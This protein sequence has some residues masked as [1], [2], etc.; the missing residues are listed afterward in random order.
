MDLV[1]VAV[2]DGR[3][4]LESLGG[5]RHAEP[6]THI[7]DLAVGDLA[8]AE[9]RIDELRGLDKVEPLV[10]AGNVIVIADH[11]DRAVPFRRWVMGLAAA[12]RMHRITRP[13]TGDTRAGVAAEA[14]RLTST[15]PM[16]EHSGA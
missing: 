10:M 15:A 14:R 16:P 13:P 4:W 6:I 11:D 1:P 3:A 7:I 9:V 5:S 2:L 8:N 12:V